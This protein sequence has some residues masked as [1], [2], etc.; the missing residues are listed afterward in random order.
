[1]GRVGRGRV[2]QERSV[3]VQVGG[4]FGVDLRPTR[5]F[6]WLGPRR[7]GER[8]LWLGAQPRISR[9]PRRRHELSAGPVRVSALGN[10]IVTLGQTGLTIARAARARRSQ[11]PERPTRGLLG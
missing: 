2:G 5:L 8:I 6:V 4:L 7:R 1:M 10:P 9:T 3:E 11:L